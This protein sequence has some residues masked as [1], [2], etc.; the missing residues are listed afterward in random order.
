MALVV[1]WRLQRRDSSMRVPDGDVVFGQRGVGASRCLGSAI[2]SRQEPQDRRLGEAACARIG[3]AR[4]NPRRPLSRPR[5][6]P[7]VDQGAVDSDARRGG[8]RARAADFRRSEILASGSCRRHR[9]SIPDPAKHAASD[10]RT[11]PQIEEY[12]ADTLQ[13]GLDSDALRSNPRPSTLAV[14]APLDDERHRGL[15]IFRFIVRAA[16][17][18]EVLDELLVSVLP[19]CTTRLRGRSSRERGRDATHVDAVDARRSGG[20][21]RRAPLAPSSFGSS[22]SFTTRRSSAAWS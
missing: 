20:P 7:R 5:S 9:A 11:M 3:A 17:Q 8:R 19:P 21:R 6:V 18:E 15:G 14:R 16:G 2:L 10:R 22:P 13:R 12:R 1:E 4:G